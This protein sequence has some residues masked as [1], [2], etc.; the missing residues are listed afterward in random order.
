MSFEPKQPP[1]QKFCIGIDAMGSDYGAEEVVAGIQRALQ[2]VASRIQKITL[3]GDEAIVR[4][5]LDRYGLSKTSLIDLQHTSEVVHM[6]E[7]PLQALKHKKEASMFQGIEG[8]QNGRW[9][10]FLSCGNTGA[11]MAGSTLKLRTIEG[12]DRPSLASIIPTKTSRFILIDVGA[13]PTH[14]AKVLVHNA[15]LG[16]HFAQAVLQLQHPR[17]GLLTIGTEEGKGDVPIQTAHTILKQCKNLSYTGLIEGFDIFQG[18]VDVVVCDGFVG[19]IILKT[20][21]SLFLQIQSFLKEKLQK[22]HIRKFGA[23]LCQGAFRDMKKQLA[24]EKF[25]GAPLLGLNG[26]VFKAHG[27][28]KAAAIAGA[29]QMMLSCIELYPIQTVTA[30]IHQA[31]ALFEKLSASSK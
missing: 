21:E 20:C 14:D 16:S 29:I 10:A 8:V 2:R 1:L 15:I 28:S 31:N 5:L 13:N 25:S 17:I 6:D 26:W 11:L 18:T 23:F 12:V 7:N 3:L 27:S 9:H 4:P 22:N 30:D 24:P 19:N